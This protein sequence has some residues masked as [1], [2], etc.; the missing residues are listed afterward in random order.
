[1]RLKIFQIVLAR[2]KKCV[3]FESYDNLLKY[4]GKAGID[5]GIYTKAFDG[6]VDAAGLE[7]VYR[8]FNIRKPG[9]YTGRSMSV[10]DIVEVVESEQ[11]CR[12][13]YY[14]NNIGFQKVGFNPD[15]TH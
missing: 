15:K 11:V 4:T 5:E 8:I 12:G 7:D 1:M 2:D 10:S 14:C 6:E 13:F 3:A 9:G